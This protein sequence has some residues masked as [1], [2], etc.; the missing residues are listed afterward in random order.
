MKRSKPAFAIEWIHSWKAVFSAKWYLPFSAALDFAFLVL[1]G[2]MTAPLLARISEHIIAIGVMLSVQMRV[3][4]GSAR[5]AVANVL[6]SPPV[7]RYT[8]QC[9]VL[10]LVLALA[11]FMLYCIFQGLAWRIAGILS[12]LKTHWRLF[13]L[14]FA[15]INLFWFGLYCLWHC[16]SIALE[17][18]S[19]FIG[20]GRTP[21]GAV[22][23]VILGLVAY[24]AIISYPLLNLRKAFVSGARN[25]LVLVPAVAIVIAQFFV[26]NAVLKLVAGISKT[27]ALVMGAIILLMLLAWSR[28]YITFVVR[29]LPDV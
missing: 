27:A 7:S 9:V 4:E 21:P 22:M 11:V 2:F 5:P 18:R 15:R 3:V 23:Y 8:L 19:I 17:L 20:A 1:Y 28:A 29:G 24:F 10:L 26:G 13:L 6:F 16:I 14:R 25:A 12:G